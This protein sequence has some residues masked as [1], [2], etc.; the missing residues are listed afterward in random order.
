MQSDIIQVLIPMGYALLLTILIEEA[1]AVFFFGKKWI[2]YLLVL[3]VNVVTNP[4][5]NLLYLW[6]NEYLYI[7]PYSPIMILLELTVVPAEYMLLAHGL[8]SSRRRWLVLSFLM[9]SASYITGLVILPMA[10]Q[11]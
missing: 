3:L 11:L 7:A 4:I 5:I 1:V 10:R 9:N 2:G 6:L 8:N